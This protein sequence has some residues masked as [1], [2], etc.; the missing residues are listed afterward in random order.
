V[1]ITAVEEC[2]GFWRI[3]TD[4]G[5]TF[6]T[7]NT[8]MVTKARE[9]CATKRNVEIDAHGGWYYKNVRAITVTDGAV[10]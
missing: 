8:G 1:T 5:Q 7:R 6:A 10:A 2:E 3:R 9:Y 4:S